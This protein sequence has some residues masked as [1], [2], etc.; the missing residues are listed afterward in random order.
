MT[1]RKKSYPKDDCPRCSGQNLWDE[2]IPK[3][4]LSIVDDVIDNM[5]K[6]KYADKISGG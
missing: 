4:E 3:S 5:F 1:F 2:N 6:E